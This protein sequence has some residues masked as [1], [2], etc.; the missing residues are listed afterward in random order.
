MVDRGTEIEAIVDH[1]NVESIVEL[2]PLD[3]HQALATSALLARPGH[4]RPVRGCIHPPLRKGQT[5]RIGRPAGAGTVVSI[6]GPVS[7]LHG[8]RR[9]NDRQSSQAPE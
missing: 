4:P 9:E 3:H 5:Q 8:L 6:S 7:G 2:H 1:G